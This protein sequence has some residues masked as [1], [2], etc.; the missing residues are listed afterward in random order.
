ML[1]E[2]RAAF[3]IWLIINITF[4]EKFSLSFNLSKPLSTYEKKSVKLLSS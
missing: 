4:L 1:P 2:F 3:F